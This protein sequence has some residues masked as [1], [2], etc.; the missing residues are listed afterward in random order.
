MY[1]TSYYTI[2]YTQCVC[3]HMCVCGGELSFTYCDIHEDFWTLQV[4]IEMDVAMPLDAALRE[5][6]TELGTIG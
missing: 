1:I 6:H 2:V 3:V 4:L 5:L